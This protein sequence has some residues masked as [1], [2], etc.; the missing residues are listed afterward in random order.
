MDDLESI[1]DRE[2]HVGG[3]ESMVRDWQFIADNLPANWP[4][5]F[6]ALR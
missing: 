6:A 1:A 2:G 5:V 4:E 3:I